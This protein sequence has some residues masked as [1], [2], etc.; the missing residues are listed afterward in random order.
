[1]NICLNLTTN[2][3]MVQRPLRLLTRFIICLGPCTELTPDWSTHPRMTLL[4]K[5]NYNLQ[6]PHRVDG[7]GF[8]VYDGALFFNKERTRNI[9][10]F[11][12]AD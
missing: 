9:V 12:F 7:T 11:D 4:L 3:G 8:V 6:A 1:M 5:A 2:L 10:K